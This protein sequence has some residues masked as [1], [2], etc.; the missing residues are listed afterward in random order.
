MGLGHD[1]DATICDIAICHMR[2]RFPTTS[3]VNVAHGEASSAL[4]DHV[5]FPAVDEG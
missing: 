3:H 5:F 1:Y 2:L 4:L